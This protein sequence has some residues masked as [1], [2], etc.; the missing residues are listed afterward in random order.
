MNQLTGNATIV[1]NFL[2]ETSTHGTKEFPFMVYLNDFSNFQNGYICWHWH[3]EVQITFIHEGTFTCQVGNEK[4]IM[5][6]G[7]IIFLNSHALHQITP[8]K[9]GYG[10]LYSFLWQPDM[11][12]GNTFSDLYKNCIKTITHSQLKYVFWS[13]ENPMHQQ[14]Q[15]SL[16]RIINIMTEK[17]TFYELRIYNQLSKIWLKLCEYTDS[18]T[19]Y[20]SDTTNLRYVSKEK[21]EERVRTALQFMKNNY[22]KN[23]SLETIAKAAMTN[24]SEL[25]KCFRRVLDITPN[26]FLIQYRI[27]EALLLLENPELRI[28]DIAEMTGFCS[29]SHFGTH[30]LK[31]VGCT[32]L[33]YRKT[34]S[35]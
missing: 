31:Y 1:D 13:K 19:L 33:Q 6:P 4:I 7:D 11:L 32:P 18:T 34:T 25:C 3:D 15:S 28:A 8:N 23:I 10:K 21:D 20:N 14:I 12:S 30:F 17:F 16:L 26:D 2:K 22:D 29:P 24:R 27:H 5:K 35:L 9:K